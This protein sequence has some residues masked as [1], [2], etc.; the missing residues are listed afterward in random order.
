[1]CDELTRQAPNVQLSGMSGQPAAGQS[2]TLVVQVQRA[3]GAVGSAT[4]SI[5]SAAVPVT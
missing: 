5:N 2:V 4:I 1:M 3:D